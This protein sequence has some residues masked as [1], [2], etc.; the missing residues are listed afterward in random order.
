MKRYNLYIMREFVETQAAASGIQFR[1]AFVGRLRG[2]Q[3]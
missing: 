1:P 3:G 2:K